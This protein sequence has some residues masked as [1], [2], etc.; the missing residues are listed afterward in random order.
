MSIVW[1]CQFCDTVKNRFQS[2]ATNHQCWCQQCG[3][4][5]SAIQSNHE[6]FQVHLSLFSVSEEK[7]KC[8]MVLST[9]RSSREVI[10]KL[11][12]NYHSLLVA[13]QITSWPSG[14]FGNIQSKCVSYHLDSVFKGQNLKVLLVKKVQL[15]TFLKFS[16]RYQMQKSQRRQN[17][18]SILIS[19]R[20]KLFKNGYK[21]NSDPLSLDCKVEKI[22]T[23]SLTQSKLRI[24][25]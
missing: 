23:K 11:R 8:K 5:N 15:T 18:R 25:Q 7:E 17:N 16:Q 4:G 14:F 3:V 12:E 20:N 22:L 6:N 24:K 2:S 21:F 19:D 13:T 9:L 1:G 10:Q